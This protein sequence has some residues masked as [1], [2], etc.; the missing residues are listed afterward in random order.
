MS[1]TIRPTLR[2]VVWS[3]IDSHGKMK[4][5]EPS[6]SSDEEDYYDSPSRK[7]RKP[8]TQPMV[9]YPPQLTPSEKLW[10]DRCAFLYQRGY[11]LRPRYQ[12][13]WSP[14]VMGNGRHHHSGED[15]IMQIVP[16]VLDAIRRQ[17]G[18]VVCVKMISEV[19]KV[20]HIKITEFFS[21][22]RMTSDT[23]NHVV[24]FY[25]CFADTYSP[26]IQF[27][28]MPVLRRFDDPEFVVVSEV[29][30]FISQ[31]L[32]GLVFLHENH[33]AHN[34]LIADHIMMDA[35]S[36][37]PTGWHF[38]SHFCEP[39]GMTRVKPLERRNHPV[40]YYFVGFGNSCSFPPGKQ[41]LVN[42]LGAE[43]EEVP[44][45]LSRKPYDPYKLDIYTLG[46]VFKRQLFQKYYSLDFI[47]DLLKYM[48]IEDF[49]QR[50]AA[51]SILQAWYRIRS[52]LDEDD[53]EN[54]RLTKKEEA[55]KLF[56][57]RLSTDK[58]SPSGSSRS[59]HSSNA[60]TRSDKRDISSILNN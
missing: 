27:M 23:R 22:R 38:V 32:E 21:T 8:L 49:A 14:A 55:K 58:P 26:N 40:R 5:R 43:D 28:V 11:Q 48:H 4:R 36:I 29:V 60:G 1:L 10:R 19:R 13:H 7:R 33:V 57:S 17:D 3:N 53:L 18:L 20:H 16:Q 50:P 37:I 6:T 41:P 46:N 52:A 31:A 44:E 34:N 47:Q 56:S 45:L 30:D 42:H 51:D 25:D 59:T 2:P 12:P 9:Y 35:K 24:P 15:H 39:D 54:T